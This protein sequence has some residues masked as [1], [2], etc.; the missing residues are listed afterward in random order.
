MTRE[1][2]VSLVADLL[3]QAGS[4]S[5][6]VFSAW[7]EIRIEWDIGDWYLSLDVDSSTM[8]AYMHQYNRKMDWDLEATFM[9]TSE[10][11]QKLFVQCMSNEFARMGV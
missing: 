8:E 3:E 9:L 5:G 10:D 4:K 7:G 1:T 2:A 11:E 6:K